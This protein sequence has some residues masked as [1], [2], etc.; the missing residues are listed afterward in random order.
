MIS[1]MLNDELV[2]ISKI[3][4]NCT[5][6]EWLRENQSLCGTKEGCGS[7]DCGACTV[8]LAELNDSQ[9]GLEYRAINSC[10]TFLSA[11]DG[12]Q[13]ITVEH[14]ADGNALHPVQQA[15]VDKHGSQCG[16][17][18]PGFVMPMFSLYK[19]RESQEQSSPTAELNRHQ[20]DNA[21][22][23]NLCRCT[24]YRPIID[25]ALDACE[26]PSA[27]KFSANSTATI[28]NLKALPQNSGTDGLHLPDSRA[29]L[30]DLLVKYPQAR[31]VAGSTDLALEVTQQYKQLPQLIS[32][33]YV[34]ELNRIE[35]KEQELVIGAAVTY[36]K[37]QDKL[38]H[39][40]PELEE[41]LA[42]LGS[43]PIRNQGTLGGN[44]ANASPIGD[45]PPVL[46]ALNAQ[47]TLD[48]GEQQRT[49]PVAEFFLDYKKTTLK[50]GEWLSDIRIPLPQEKATTEGC[51]RAYKISKRFEDDISA[52]CAVFNITLEQG[53]V[54]SLATGFGG[55]AAVPAVCSAL[56]QA[57]TGKAW[58]LDTM[59][60][61]KAILADA[62]TPIDDVR[63]SAQYRKTM[64]VNLWQRFWLESNNQTQAELRVI[65]HA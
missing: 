40:Y 19:T 22:S 37:L 38:L 58:N 64:L 3:D 5:V 57:V 24:G 4:N 53:V 12:K 33:R 14:L 10:I 28:E 55:V 15:M 50:K 51:L 6:L 44:V 31:L 9:N 45:T 46:L 21:L 29:A 49:I 62:F 60:Q 16:F 20:I 59:K 8:V 1:F 65:Q 7:G 27:D 2:H 41:L 63:A 48:N 17:C 30:A 26:A 13:L 35:E 52:V 43:L 23:G 56:E 36:S 34:P 32:T 11:L 39:Y 42:R 47:L 54:K 18:T 25:A 61:G